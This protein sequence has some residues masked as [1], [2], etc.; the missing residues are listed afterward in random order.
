MEGSRRDIMVRESEAKSTI[1]YVLSY[2]FVSVVLY[3][4]QRSLLALAKMR[5]RYCDWTI[6]QKDLDLTFLYKGVNTYLHMWRS[7]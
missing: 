5:G 6:G 4:W 2:E 7:I 3:R 1:L